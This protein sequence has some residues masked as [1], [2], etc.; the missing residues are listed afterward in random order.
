MN[1]NMSRSS[2][3]ISTGSSLDLSAHA[4]LTMRQQSEDHIRT[5]TAATTTVLPLSTSSS[6]SSSSSQ[7]H[8]HMRMLPPSSAS[9][10]ALLLNL[11]RSTPTHIAATHIASKKKL[12]ARY[13]AES[14]HIPES[15]SSNS[16]S[17]VNVN[18]WKYARDRSHSDGFLSLVEASRHL[19]DAYG[20]SGSG[21]HN[22]SSSSELEGQGEE[23]EEEEIENDTH[24]E[25]DASMLSESSGTAAMSSPGGECASV[26]ALKNYAKKQDIVTSTEKKDG[27]VGAY[28]PESRK[29]RIERFLRSRQKRV[30]T[31]KVKYDVRKNFAD[32]RLRVKGRFVKKEDEMLMRDL[33]SIT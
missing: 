28:S 24:G 25:E 33:M 30:W 20:G 4:I 2:V 3:N 29:L 22:V 18:T 7:Q 10:C 6:P 8:H 15:R 17:F 14:M 27:W 13:R 26:S 1:Y 12:L 16:N 32:S 23:E 19:E 11:T 21:A 9:D 5:T 31:K